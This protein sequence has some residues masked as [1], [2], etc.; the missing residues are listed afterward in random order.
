MSDWQTQATVYHI[1]EEEVKNEW[2]HE[3]RSRGLITAYEAAWESRNTTPAIF[4]DQG[5]KSWVAYYLATSKI[6]GG[7]HYK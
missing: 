3:R 2:T 6:S 1:L 4:L 5:L 7:K